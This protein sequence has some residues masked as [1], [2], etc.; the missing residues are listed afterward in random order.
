MNYN[1]TNKRIFIKRNNDVY[2]VYVNDKYIYSGDSLMV[3]VAKVE[4]LLSEDSDEGER[5]N[6]SI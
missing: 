1:V 6:G 5:N 4:E 2:D 3:A